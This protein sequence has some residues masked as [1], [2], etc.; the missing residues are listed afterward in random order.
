[1]KK[2]ICLIFGHNKILKGWY[3][4]DKITTVNCLRCG[5]IL[6]RYDNPNYE[7]YKWI[8]PGGR[9]V[10]NDTELKPLDWCCEFGEARDNGRCRRAT[11][12]KYYRLKNDK[13]GSCWDNEP[14]FLC[15]EHS[16]NHKRC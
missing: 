9:V 1:M 11:V 10:K 16:I 4:S 3:S 5:K 12:R 6:E 7:E 13:D 2:I 8:G 15:D 14:I